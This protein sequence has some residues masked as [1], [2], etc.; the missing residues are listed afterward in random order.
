MVVGGI[1]GLTLFHLII[2]RDRVK[3][4]LQ[5]SEDLLTNQHGLSIHPLPLDQ[6]SRSLPPPRWT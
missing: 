3:G 5:Y 1:E 2:P 4:F 6:S